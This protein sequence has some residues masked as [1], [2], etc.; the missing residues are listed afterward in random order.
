MV[1]QLSGLDAFMYYQ[2]SPRTPNHLGPL[3]TYDP[4]T[5]PGGELT[6]E[7]F[8][9]HVANRVVAT[10]PELRQ[11]LRRVPLD[12]DRPYWV[13]DEHIDL[14]IHLRHTALPAPGNWDQLCTQ[15][16]R[17]H[18]RPLDLTRPP[19]EMWFI[20]G[21][22]TVQG[23]PPGSFA[24][25]LK[26][27]HA[28]ID[29]VAGVQLITA[30]HDSDPVSSA[31]PGAATAEEHGESGGAPSTTRM[32]ATAAVHL[33]RTPDALVRFAAPLVS[34]TAPGLAA[35]LPGLVASAP[36]A[37]AAL[38]RAL[39]ALSRPREL[40]GPATRFGGR[41]SSHRV[42]DA[43]RIPL[44]SLKAIRAVAPGATVNDVAVAL[45]A[46]GLRTYLL[47]KD[48]LPDRPLSTIMPISV[49]V[50]GAEGGNHVT[51][52][53]VTVATHLADP[54]E[55]L[56]AT[57]DATRAAKGMST[58]LG[59]HALMD[60]SHALPGALLGVGVRAVNR[61]NVIAAASVADTTITNVPGPPDPMYLAGARSVTQTGLTPL[62]DGMGLF[63]AMTSYCGEATIAFTACQVM[64]PDPERYTGALLQSLS[65]LAEAAGLVGDPAPRVDPKQPAVSTGSRG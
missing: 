52:V 3:M 14:D 1:R 49:R 13:D 58:A 41:V 36:R 62:L 28:A 54:V 2:E 48:E 51:M 17:I 30:L 32:L 38:P 61:F 7:Q 5:A 45:V 29:G 42:F 46:G 23:C 18:A 21:L 60:V 16:A 20:E 59:A 8:R 50:P 25:Y 57:R 19:W 64:M 34:R 39:R 6:F 26:I 35:R 44:A 37:P 22:N 65:E 15:V 47:E 43:V 33:V 24:L 31:D 63:H 10:L 9:A 27:H 56:A 11:R 53:P 40:V 55:R 4:T 12:L